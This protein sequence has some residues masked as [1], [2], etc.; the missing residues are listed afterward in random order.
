LGLDADH[1][2]RNVIPLD[3]D[4][5]GDLDLAVQSLQG[6]RFYMN[7]GE[8]AAYARIRLQGAAPGTVVR[9][10]AAGSTRQDHYK[11]TDGFQSQPPTDMHFGLDGCALIDEI[12]VDWPSGNSQTWAKQPVGRLLTLSDGTES[13]QTSQL[14]SWPERKRAYWSADPAAALSEWLGEDQ[15]AEGEVCVLHWLGTTEGDPAPQ[16]PA[17]LTSMASGFE[18]VRWLVVFPASAEVSSQSTREL[19][20]S[21]NIQCLSETGAAVR[22]CFGPSGRPSGPA[23]FVMRG[24]SLR[25]THFP[26]V[27]S[28]ETAD[29][30]REVLH[31]LEDEAAFPTPLLW[32]ARKYLDEGDP[33]SALEHFS[34]L[35]KVSPELAPAYEGMARALEQLDRLPEAEHA[36][37][38]SIQ[39]DP[40]YAIG[41][42]NL[43][44]VR[45]RLGKHEQGIGPIRQALRIQGERLDTL[46]TLGEICSL[47]GRSELALDAFQRA[48][49]ADATSAKAFL[50]Q[51]KML[52]QMRRLPEAEQSLIRATSLEPENQEARDALAL[53]R[54]LLGRE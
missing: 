20:Q 54:R 28:E 46:I 39:A 12:H 4:G 22:S 40:D 5:D 42:F 8:R 26:E 34:E 51:G 49:I 7:L 10:S 33:A 36:Y 32:R 35:S 38:L 47:A 2:G 50:L 53:T 44:L 37:E 45:S 52:G 29:L 9:V 41:H 27:H 13:A 6:L 21:A 16:V 17:W 15:P 1:D 25:R 48:G 14:A 31:S 19:G 43:G 3:I 11:W 24:R 30:I 18:H 23:T